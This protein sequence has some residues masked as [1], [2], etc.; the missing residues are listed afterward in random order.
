MPELAKKYEQRSCYYENVQRKCVAIPVKRYSQVSNHR[1][2]NQDNRTSRQSK[3]NNVKF[4]KSRVISRILFI[5]LMVFL[6]VFVLPSGFKNVT[7]SMF[8]KSP[9]P[10]LKT[11]YKKLVFPINKYVH[12]NLFLNEPLLSGAVSKK[13]AMAELN[14]GTELTTLESHI[15]NI[16]PMY[17]SI[18]PSVYVWEY[19]TGNY[20]D[21]NGSEIFSAASIIKIPVLIQLFKSIESNQ[22]SLYDEMPLTEY[23][24]SEGSGNLQFK[25]ANSTYSLDKLARIMITESDNSATN[26]IM[27]K[28]G[29]MTDVNQGLRDWGLKQTYVN[30]WL[31]DLEGTNHTTAKDLARMLFN[32][33]NTDFLTADSREKILDY[34]GHVKNNR[35]IQAGLGNGAAF[36]HKTGDIGKMLGDAGIVST[37]GGK[38]YIVVILANRPYNSPAG[39]DFIVKTSEIIYNYM[40]N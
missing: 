35:L 24:R 15:S 19:G 16:L 5:S 30:N 20:A 18:H 38:K 23:Y 17:P 27:S 13:P 4:E 36:F 28:I 1:S 10:N 9:Y 21:I 34:M 29:S 25:A 3:K 39:K 31:P 11:D 6:C 8:T 26:M 32:I 33:E 40:A 37:P 12:N 2:L 14:E 22:V 7:L